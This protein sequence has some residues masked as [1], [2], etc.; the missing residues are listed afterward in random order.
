MKKILLVLS[1]LLVIGLGGCTTTDERIKD[2]ATCTSDEP[3]CIKVGF[4]A[5]SDTSYSA[6]V[7]LED[8]YTKEEVD[9]MIQE[10]EDSFDA[11]AMNSRIHGT[12]RFWN[13]TWRVSWQ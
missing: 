8:Y 2:Y 3:S 11:K 1:L 5:T 4:K 6:Y 9:L 12:W 13:R 7:N 10:I